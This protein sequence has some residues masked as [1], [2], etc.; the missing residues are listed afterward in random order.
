MISYDVIVKVDAPRRRH[1][2][3]FITKDGHRFTLSVFSMLGY[4]LIGQ[5]PLGSYLKDHGG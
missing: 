3:F 4:S 5:L 2:L 1:G